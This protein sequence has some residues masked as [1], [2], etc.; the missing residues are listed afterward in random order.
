MGL[1]NLL[2][3]I[4]FVNGVKDQKPVASVLSDYASATGPEDVRFIQQTLPTYGVRQGTSLLELQKRGDEL[5]KRH[6]ETQK[7]NQ[8]AGALSRFAED[9]G[10]N[11]N[12]PP[13]YV[14][15]YQTPEDRQIIAQDPKSLDDFTRGLNT[16]VKDYQ[17]FNLTRAKNDQDITDKKQKETWAKNYSE[18]VY[19]MSQ[20]L[21]KSN[22]GRQDNHTFP[23]YTDV[24]SQ[25]AALTKDYPV[26][27]TQSD[28]LRDD[29]VKNMEKSFSQDP[30]YYTDTKV[31]KDTVTMVPNRYGYGNKKLDVDRAPNINVAVQN[32][33]SNRA[34]RRDEM[35]LRK[36]FDSLPEVK[37]YKESY[38]KAQQAVTALQQPNI[39]KDIALTYNF[40]KL[41]DPESVVREGEYERL[42]K[43]QSFMSRLRGA[44]GRIA[45]G[46]GGLDNKDRLVVAQAIKALSKDQKILYDRAARNYKQYAKDYGFESRRIVGDSDIGDEGKGR[47]VVKTGTEKTT[48]RKVVQ[49]DDGTTDYAD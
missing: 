30:R 9:Y 7:T 17:D 39:T 42:F 31:G 19:P 41:L 33:R 22:V 49:Y 23:N 34:D 8:R 1:G 32:E 2:Q 35:S 21:L 15:A 27:P 13:A 10:Q 25:F 45:E 3:L 47:K 24:L 16:G 38:V 5:L 28:R 18:N 26:D 29:L 12:L 14:L 48:G 36:E 6:D 20:D 46:G 44:V 43:N 4:E 37:N 40:N 11:T